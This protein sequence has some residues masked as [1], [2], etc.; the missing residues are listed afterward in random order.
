MWTLNPKPTGPSPT[1]L[2][3]DPLTSEDLLART[4]AL[5]LSSWSRRSGLWL[6]VWGSE[7]TMRGQPSRKLRYT[8]DQGF[9]SGTYVDS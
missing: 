5:A 2:N 4:C 9:K 8:R 6:R 1:A 3:L 7:F